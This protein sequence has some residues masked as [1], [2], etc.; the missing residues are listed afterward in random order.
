MAMF[1]D[2][3]HAQGGRGRKFD[4]KFPYAAVLDEEGNA[5]GQIITAE[6]YDHDK[7]KGRICCPECGAALKGT[8]TYIK[9]GGVKS[10]PFFS[11]YDLSDHQD[12]DLASA[13]EKVR[14]A[15]HSKLK[16]FTSLGSK[17]IYWNF[18]YPFSTPKFD[19]K[20][21]SP[22][23]REGVKLS[24]RTEND[25]ASYNLGSMKEFLKMR[26]Y[27][28]FSD[29]F[30]ND[31]S[32]YIREHR[33]PWRDFVFGL[34]HK[35]LLVSAFNESTRG[36][37]LPKIGIFDVL[38]PDTGF[39][40]PDSGIYTLRCKPRRLTDS[41]D[42]SGLTIFLIQPIIQTKNIDVFHELC[43]GG[44]FAVHGVPSVSP[45]EITGVTRGFRAGEIK[46]NQLR[47]FI[48]VGSTNDIINVEDY[49]RTKEPD[50]E[51]VPQFRAPAAVAE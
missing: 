22:L 29:S 4:P 9:L 35:G 38:K 24:G 10:T 50:P 14:N 5:T 17:I 12:C 11:S 51:D 21:F 39:Y 44:P 16:F 45:L 25:V 20:G 6:Q 27:R 15:A 42:P 47:V 41:K 7:H 13:D 33:I 23:Q 34:N 1:A 19:S 43:E 48:N 30:Y 49:L 28:D 8:P 18:D 31:V 46:Q 32:I 37:T 2:Y 3:N 36:V 40:N 26:R